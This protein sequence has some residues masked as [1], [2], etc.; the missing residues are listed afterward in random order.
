MSGEKD[1]NEDT[2]EGRVTRS[3]TMKKRSEEAAKKVVPV[4]SEDDGKTE[5]EWSPSSA[6]KKGGNR[7]S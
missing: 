3:A 5:A 2:G 7:C 4:V 6:K 1:S